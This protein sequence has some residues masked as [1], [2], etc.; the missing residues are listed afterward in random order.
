MGYKTKNIYRV[1]DIRNSVVLVQEEIMDSGQTRL[2]RIYGLD[3][4]KVLTC[5][6]LCCYMFKLF[7]SVNKGKMVKREL[8]FIC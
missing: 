6:Y 4:I 8:N 1:N 7:Y 3:L 2:K 5:Q